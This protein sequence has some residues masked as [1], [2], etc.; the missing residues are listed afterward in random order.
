MA[1]HDLIR[2]PAKVRASIGYISQ[3]GGADNAATGREDLLL[4][5][6]LSGMTRRAA[7]TRV[8]ALVEQLEL[9]PFADCLVMSNNPPNKGRTQQVL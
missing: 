5:A 7:Q 4:Q 9:A 2:K 1:G 8:A 6:Q 3:I